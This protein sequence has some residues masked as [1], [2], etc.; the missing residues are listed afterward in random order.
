MQKRICTRFGFAR[1][2]AYASETS[3]INLSIPIYDIFRS[4]E[5]LRHLAWRSI[6]YGLETTVI[7]RTSLRGKRYSSQHCFFIA[8][9]LEL[10][11]NNLWSNRYCVYVCIHVSF[12]QDFSP[13]SEVRPEHIS[14]FWFGAT[15]ATPLYLRKTSGSVFGVPV[16]FRTGHLMNISEGR[17]S[18]WSTVDV[19]KTHNLL[20]R[21]WRGACLLRVSEYTVN[22]NFI[23]CKFILNKMFVLC[24][25]VL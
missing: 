11:G 14:Y 3:F 17:F 2:L 10:Y 20:F 18:I 5:K 6:L 1:F 16:E 12:I 9:R 8:L 7:K 23:N 25:L 13:L 15:K 4:G 24:L 19:G 21:K 22:R